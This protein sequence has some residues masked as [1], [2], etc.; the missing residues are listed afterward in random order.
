[1]AHVPSGTESARPFLPARDFDLSRRFYVT[2]GF[3]KV[4]DG[5]V[6]VFRVGS[7]GFVDDL[8]AWWVHIVSLDLQTA[9]PGI[10]SYGQRLTFIAAR[11]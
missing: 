9:R 2:L 11:L 7:S 3:E 10:A 1:M 5:D 6:A 4:L 8:D